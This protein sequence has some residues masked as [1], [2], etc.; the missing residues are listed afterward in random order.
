MHNRTNLTL[1]GV[2]LASLV[3]ASGCSGGKDTADTAAGTDPG[4][5]PATT[6][7]P[8]VT[9]TEYTGEQYVIEEFGGYADE[10]D[11]IDLD[12]DG[13]NDNATPSAL[14][15]VDAFVKYDMTVDGLNGTIAA[16]IAKNQL[17]ILMET[18]YSD[19]DLTLDIL[20]GTVAGSGAAAPDQS[21][22]DDAGDPL[23]QLQGYFTSDT[24]FYGT[25][26]RIQVG[27][28]F[29]P[30]DPPLPLPMEMVTVMGTADEEGISGALYGA[31]PA[32]DLMDLMIIPLLEDSIV[33]PS[34]RKTMISLVED[35]LDYETVTDI[36]LGDGRRGISCAFYFDGTDTTW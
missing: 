18:T 28:T 9:N 5:T 35:V 4:T 15:L 22:Y 31:I 16:A 2:A 23:S 25:A 30:K 12:G 19:A 21:S 8:P 27:V 17:I 6:A 3:A 36:D 13:D 32:D 11:G 24:E 20:T 10:A 34:E 29:F 1:C 33:D 7:P 26:D 14:V